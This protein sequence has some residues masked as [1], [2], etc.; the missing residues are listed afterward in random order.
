ME[1]AEKL[2]NDKKTEP[3]LEHMHNHPHSKA[4]SNRLAKAIGHL[5]AVKRMVDRGD[6]CSEILT[7]IAAVAFC[8]PERGKSAEDG[9]SESLYRTCSGRK[10]L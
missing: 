7:Q 1:N 2:R 3:S 10:R 6:D 4:V 8:Y 5:E 9:S